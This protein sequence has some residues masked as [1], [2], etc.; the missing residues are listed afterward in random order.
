MA[1]AGFT[2]IQLYFSTTAA[3]VPTSGNLANGELAINITDGKLYYKSNAGVVTLLAG[4]TAGPA[5]GSNTQVQFNS[6]GALAGSANMTFDGTTLTVAGLSNTGNT[7]LGNASADTLTVN[8]TITSNLIFTDNTYDIGASG[9]TRPRNLYT[10]GIGLFGGTLF[11][12]SAQ[13][14]TNKL[15]LRDNSLEDY[16]TNSNASVAVNY[17]G[18]LAGTTQFRDFDIY[19]GK[20]ASIAVF[21]GA[22]SRFGLNNANPSYLFDMTGQGRVLSTSGASGATIPSNNLFV[23][24]SNANTG[25]GIA[26]PSTGNIVGGYYING[27]T[28]QYDG[29]IEYQGTTRELRLL[30][31]GAN[32]VFVNAVSLSVGATPYASSR[33]TVQIVDA[34]EGYFLSNTRAALGANFTYNANN[35]Y[36]QNGFAGYFE[37]DSTSGSFKWLS[38]ATGLAGGVVTFSQPMSLTAGGNLLVG[39]TGG[40]GYRLYVTAAFSSTV[41]GAYIEAGEF[42]QSVMILN[43]TNASVGV[44]LFQVQKSGTGVLTLDADGDLGITETSPAAKL[45]ISVA[46]AAVDGTKG[47]KI[48]NPAGTIVVLEC[49]VSSDS[50]V[51][52][53]SGSDFSIRSNNTERLKFPNAGGVQAVT[54]ISV[55]NATPSASGAGITFPATVSLS[56]NAN[57]LDDYEEG[58]WTPN[59][60]FGGSSTGITYSERTG[61]YIK[62][63]KQVTI[64]CTIYLSSKG[65]STGDATFTGVPFAPNQTYYNEQHGCVGDVTN[66]T[67]SGYL[68]SRVGGSSIVQIFQNVSGT[69]FSTLTNTNYSNNSAIA[70]TVTYTTNA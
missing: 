25:F 17:T 1:Q 11:T 18:Y 6:S 44:P 32:R 61:T 8:S 50:F 67:F 42:N 24:D 16:A 47:V 40:T 38:A 62:I 3:A 10:S 23:V 45:H 53:T 37:V 35:L 48:T 9:A 2:P 49:G 41:G 34:D 56:S 4:A 54:T 21:K 43:H 65:S 19:N 36:M 30:A 69:G 39:N 29:G 14:G 13:L 26:I 58:S 63:G 51:G 46:S 33:K 60:A 31:Q 15:T 55:G 66:V 70:F 59:L 57:T 52:T 28:N 12:Q 20:A 7:T 5:G 64:W 68:D 22:T 27:G